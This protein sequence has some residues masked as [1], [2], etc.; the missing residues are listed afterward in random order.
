MVREYEL[1]YIVRP[2][3]DEEGLQAA[4]DSVRKLIE[5]LGGEIRKTTMWGKRR[6]A[7][8]VNRLRD[9]H[10]VILKLQMDGSKVRDVERAL[11][12]HDTVFR[13]LIVID[14]APGEAEEEVEEEQPGAAATGE[15][16]AAAT[17]EAD[18]A[19]TGESDPAAAPAAEESAESTDEETEREPVAAGLDEEGN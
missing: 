9:G 13:H 19:E 15:A 5:G 16:D 3:L 8:E 1:M 12:I 18:A 14:E 6:L 2:E 11:A 17:G 10:Y 4:A 7:Y